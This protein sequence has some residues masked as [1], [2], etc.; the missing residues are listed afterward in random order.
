[1]KRKLE[2]IANVTVIVMALAVGYV[3]LGRYAADFRTP[4][5]VSAGDRLE[6]APDLDWTRHRHTLVLA[7]N[8]GCHFCEQSVPFYQKLASAQPAARD[9]LELVAVFPNDP[10]SVRQYMSREDL[11]IRSVSAVALDKLR[12][13]ATPTIFLVNSSGRVERAWIG[14]LTPNE[15]LDVLKVVS[16]SPGCSSGEFAAAQEGAK[17]SCDPVTKG[18]ARN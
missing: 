2:A 18:Q 17:G 8:T 15:E 12:V 10:D 6:A 9:D 1:M 14:T 4:R 7:L 16:A 3:V 13:D 5:P 11:R